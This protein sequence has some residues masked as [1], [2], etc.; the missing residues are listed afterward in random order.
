[1][2]QITVAL[3]K[4]KM[5]ICSAL[6]CNSTGGWSGFARPRTDR[7]TEGFNPLLIYVPQF[8]CQVKTQQFSILT[9]IAIFGALTGT[10]AGPKRPNLDTTCFRF[11]G[12]REIKSEIVFTC[13]P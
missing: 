8:L 13:F 12:W 6:S 1:M 4:S 9:K 7:L 5:V 10:K 3:V 2:P 11:P